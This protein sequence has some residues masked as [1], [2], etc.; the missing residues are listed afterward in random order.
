MIKI[1]KK[2]FF[3]F[4]TFVLLSETATAQMVEMKKEKNRTKEELKVTAFL[5][6][7]PFGHYAEPPYPS[8]FTSIFKPI[9]EDYAKKQNFEVTYVL[10]PNY[11]TLVRDVRRGEI[12]ML[13]GMYHETAMYMG[14]EYVFPAAVNNPIVAIMLPGRI[15][16]VKSRADLKKL[17]GAM[18]T[19]EHLSDFVAQELKQYNVKK[20]EKSLDMYERLFAGQIDYII[21]SRYFSMIEAMKL[22]IY[23]K[24]S[25]SKQAIWNMPLFIGISKTSFHKK[26]LSRTFAALMEDPRTTKRIEQILIDTI[27]KIEK[28]TEGVVPPTFSSDKK[29]SDIDDVTVDEQPNTM[30]MILAPGQRKS[31]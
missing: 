8:S 12:D 4:L 5:D 25:F 20:F 7:P 3:L 23:N 2:M 13:L 24:V 6:Y 27:K 17:R 31:R 19:H 21:G 18:S 10:S 15:H 22:G 16:E 26:F 11:S 30:I 14:L 29:L 9:I 1:A 28:E